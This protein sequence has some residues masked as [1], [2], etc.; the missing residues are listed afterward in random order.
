MSC[1]VCA[2]RGGEGSRA[3]QLEAIRLSKEMGER[4]VFLYVIDPYSLGE[5]DDTLIA[6]V[7]EELDWMGQTL[8][9]IAQQRAH[10]AGLEASMAIRQGDVRAEIS[11]FLEESEAK[12]LLLGAPRGAT[13][14]VFGDDAVEQ[15]ALAVE[16]KTN[17]PV[18]IVR[19]ETVEG[20][21]TA[22][23]PGQY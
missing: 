20:E 16:E 17:I 11:R 18:Q 13:A 23:M 12:R 15:F 21:K 4:L 14:N 3:A 5:F 2:T 7:K 19:P 9:G 1:I 6:A 10:M 8:L 22:V